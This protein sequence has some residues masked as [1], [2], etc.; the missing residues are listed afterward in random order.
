MEFSTSSTALLFGKGFAIATI[1]GLTGF[2]IGS[3]IK[4]Y[5][6]PITE[7]PF[8]DAVIDQ[9]SLP[10]DT[11]T[12]QSF[13]GAVGTYKAGDYRGAIDQFS[14]VLKQEPN[15][16]EAFHNL[17]LA[18]ANIGDNDKALR[19]FLKASDAY[20]KQNTKEGIDRIKQDLELLKAAS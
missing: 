14:D 7:I 6:Q 1:V 2:A 9:S 16:A 11:A 5:K 4:A 8:P 12:H 15:C 3:M 18:Y 20:D 19:S 17:G 10:L 13:V